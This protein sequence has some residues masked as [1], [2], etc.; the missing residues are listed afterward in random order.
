MKILVVSDLHVEWQKDGGK[1]LIGSLEKNVDV[2]VVAGDLGTNVWLYEGLKMICAQ[3]KHVVFVAG[4]HE[5][6]GSGL[7]EEYEKLAKLQKKLKNLH[8]LENNEITI[9]GQRFIGATLWFER[10]QIAEDNKHFMSDFVQIRDFQNMPFS[11]YELSRQYIKH[12]TK[13]G[14]IVI[15]HHMP[16]YKC[17][18]LRFQNSPY[19]CYF[20]NNMDDVIEEKQPSYWLFGHTHCSVD[21][22]IGS[23]RCIANPFGY[24]GHELNSEFK[25]NL[26]IEV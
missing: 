10:N 11:K 8:W 18:D 24:A 26:I 5:F 22:T 9:D 23:T 25:E 13:P 15:T 19:N 17:V 4:N 12:Q 1:S 3:Y 21:I 7:K 2:C 6:Y 20:A 14:D 16:S